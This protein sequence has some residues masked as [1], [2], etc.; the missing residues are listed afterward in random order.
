MNENVYHYTECGLSNIYLINGYKLVE[1]SQGNAVSI[2]DIDGLHKAIG[3]FLVHSKKDFYGDE[4]RF[5]RHEML[6]S[7]ATL[8][9]LLGVS[10]QTVRRW[11]NNKIN[12]PKP[13]ESLLRL[14][15]LEKINNRHGKISKI[16]SEIA[17]LEDQINNKKMLFEDT[18][19]G[20]KAA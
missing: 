8:A 1:T 7:Q 9:D 2:N 16:L 14:L 18:S 6:I 20:W 17:N 5:L 19:K 15:Y 11:E 3:M 10:E 4:I 12:I 13:S